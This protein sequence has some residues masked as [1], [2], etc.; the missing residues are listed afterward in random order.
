MRRKTV[1]D[2]HAWNSAANGALYAQNILNGLIK[3]D[4]QDKAAL[5]AS[6]NATSAN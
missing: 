3:A 4:P 1:T 2:P 5:E 6:G